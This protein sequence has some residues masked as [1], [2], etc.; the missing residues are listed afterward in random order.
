MTFQGG[1]WLVLMPALL[2]LGAYLWRPVAGLSIFILFR[3][4]ADGFHHFH[5]QVFGL[6]LNPAGALGIMICLLGAWRLP[7]LVRRARP[8]LVPWIFLGSALIAALLSGWIRFGHAHVPVMLQEAVR[9]SVV[10]FYMILC[11]RL[12]RRKE[13]QWLFRVFWVGILGCGAW[14]LVQWLTGG[15]VFEGK[16]GVT[17]ATGPFAFPNTLGY[18]LLLGLN[19]LAAQFLWLSRSRRQII[20]L[21]VLS[22]LLLFFLGLTASI[23]VFALVVLSAL[24]FLVLRRRLLVLA[25]LLVLFALSSPLMVPRVSML[26]SSRPGADLSDGHARNTLTARFLIWRDLLGVYKSQPMF[27]TG[28]KTIARVNPVIDYIRGVGSDPHNDLVLFLVEGG[29]VG[30]VLFLSFQVSALYVLARL[31]DHSRENE[32]GVKTVALW[33]MMV[34]MTAGSLGNNLLSFTAFLCLFWGHVGL[35]WADQENGTE[36]IGGGV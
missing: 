12:S 34:C 30:L 8:V 35:V 1:G 16:S 19:L 28:L 25:A 6:S 5:F 15:G 31:A 10:F 11:A 2:V 33:V 3:L 27:G 9:L 4:A 26:L 17:R 32:T 36:N 7:G 29:L 22:G 18:V 14:G 21:C 24:I 23:T 20:G 13:R